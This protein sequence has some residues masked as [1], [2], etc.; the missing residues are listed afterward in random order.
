MNVIEWAREEQVERQVRITSNEVWYAT[1]AKG[2][3]ERL[4]YN[5]QAN[6]RANLARDI[7]GNCDIFTKA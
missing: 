1:H 2:T 3:K 4:H 6:C 5:I 7:N